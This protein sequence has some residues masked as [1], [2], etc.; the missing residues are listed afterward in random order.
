M[1]LDSAAANWSLDCWTSIALQGVFIRIGPRRTRL[2]D[3]IGMPSLDCNISLISFDLATLISYRPQKVAMLL[4][5]AM[6]IFKMGDFPLNQHVTRMSIADVGDA[7]R[8]THTFKHT[9]KVVLEASKHTHV[10]IL[11][12]RHAASPRDQYGL[13]SNAMYLIAGGLGDLGQK[14]CR[15]MASRGAKY[16]VVLSRRTLSND[17]RKAFKHSKMTFD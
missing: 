12:T 6:S 5:K 16:L 11:G 17:G 13:D 15:L 14:V 9:E 2:V 4:Q 10:K 3:Q 1:V 7:F 8:M